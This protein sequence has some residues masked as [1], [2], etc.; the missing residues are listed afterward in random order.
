M[1]FFITKIVRKLLFFYPMYQG[2]SYLSCVCKRVYVLVIQSYLTLRDF[3]D[4]S[5]P[6]SSAHGNL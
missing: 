5:L 3:M 1:F 6:G 2:G 4:C